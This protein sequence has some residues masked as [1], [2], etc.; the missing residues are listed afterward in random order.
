[1]RKLLFFVLS[2]LLFACSNTIKRYGFEDGVKMDMFTK[3]FI[4]DHFR[5]P[6]TVDDLIRFYINFGK[7]DEEFYRRQYRFLMKNKRKLSVKNNDTLTK[8]Y[9][10]NNN[11]VIAESYYFTPCEFQALDD[12][13]NRKL[14]FDLDGYCFYSEELSE[15]IRLVYEIF[16]KYEGNVQYKNPYIMILEYTPTKVLIDI[17]TSEP[18]DFG[19]PEYLSETEQFL[20]SFCKQNSLSRVIFPR[21]ADKS[22]Q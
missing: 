6:E 2:F 20:V 13:R 10:K 21:N 1:M 18:F 8:V 15:Q 4:Y 16:Q 3:Y 11:I 9:H 19:N 14:F 17:C 7:S 5:Q 12:L 22:S